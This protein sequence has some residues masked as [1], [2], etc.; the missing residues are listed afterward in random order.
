MWDR[1]LPLLRL[2]CVVLVAI[3]AARCQET[4][5]AAARDWPLSEITEH[6]VTV[7]LKAVVDDAGQTWVEGR[8]TPTRDGFHLY[9]KDLPRD[10]LSGIGRPTLL[11]VPPDGPLS[12]RGALVA[13]QTPEPLHVDAL[14]LTFPVYPA[15]PVTLRLPV[16]VRP[17]RNRQ[18]ILSLTYLACSDSVCLAP[19]SRKPVVVNLPDAL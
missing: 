19:V 17:G 13:D 14:N 9:A 10:G 11:E 1:M 8:F 15:G 3:G 2:T 7:S 4:P 12:A 6:D 5:R 16:T 18:A